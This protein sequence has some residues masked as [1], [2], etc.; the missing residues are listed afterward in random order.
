MHAPDNYWER[1]CGYHINCVHSSALRCEHRWIE[2]CK[3]RTLNRTRKQ[4]LYTRLSDIGTVLVGPEQV[5]FTVHITLI[6]VFSD[7][8]RGAFEGRFEEGRT[9]RVVLEDDSPADFAMM[10]YWLYTGDIYIPTKDDYDF[11][12]ALKGHDGASEAEDGS[13][14]VTLPS[15]LALKLRFQD[16]LVG[17]YILADKRGVQRLKNDILTQIRDQKSGSWPLLISSIDRISLACYNLPDQDPLRA[18]LEQEA[19]QSWTGSMH[20]SR[21]EIKKLPP[22]FLVNVMHNILQRR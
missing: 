2:S 22:D 16:S 6:S 15:S 18:W 10:L 12:D 11:L 3:Q 4:A 1:V 14:W 19:S 7:F 5:P 8:F 17:L 9:R 13:G 21:S 20:L